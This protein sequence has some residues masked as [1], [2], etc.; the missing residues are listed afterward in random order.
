MV[1]CGLWQL[2][3]AIWPSGSGM[4]ERRLNC[5][6]MSLWQVAQVSLIDCLA[7]R[8]SADNLAIGLWQSLHDRSLRWCTEP[9][10][11]RRPPAWQPRATGGLGLGGSAAVV[12]E[13]DDRALASR[14]FGVDGT[15]P[16]AG[17][18][19][20]RRRIGGQRHAHTQRVGGVGEVLFL[21]RMAGGADFLAD[22]PGVWRLRIVRRFGVGEAGRALRSGCAGCLSSLPNWVDG[23]LWDWYSEASCVSTAGEPTCSRRARW[24]QKTANLQELASSSPMRLAGRKAG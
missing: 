22:R 24:P 12:G 23:R 15:R 2:T 7:V 1:P 11:G 10:Q 16:V 17:F 13:G 19:G 20:R 3:Q 9:V 14:V 5:W 6:R 8:P 21:A 4:C 18:A